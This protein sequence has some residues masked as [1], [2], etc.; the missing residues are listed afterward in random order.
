MGQCEIEDIKVS[1]CNQGNACKQRIISVLGIIGTKS[2]QGIPGVSW[3]Q[4]DE[5]EKVAQGTTGAQ[6]IPVITGSQ[7]STGTQGATVT[8][9]LQG[10]TGQKSAQG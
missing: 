4:A 5:D 7:G 2:P 9:V 10:I 8:H 3:A 6:G 1:K